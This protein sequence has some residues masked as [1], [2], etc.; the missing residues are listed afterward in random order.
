MIRTNSEYQVTF[1]PF[2]DRHELVGALKEIVNGTEVGQRYKADFY[3]SERE[4]EDLDKLI[5]SAQLLSGETNI[6][7]NDLRK[8]LVLL[9]DSGELQPREF[10]A[11]TKLE[12]PEPDV[13]PRDKNGKLLTQQQIEWAEYRQFAESHSSADCR[14]RARTDSGFAN[15]MRKNLEREMSQPVGDAVVP[16]GQANSQRTS[17]QTSGDLVSFVHAFRAEPSENLRPKGGFVLLSG[18]KIPH[19]Q[20]IEQIEAA[21]NAGLL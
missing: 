20:L 4:D 2:E 10:V 17:R 1:D 3:S 15:F 19:S 21:T 5:R 18:R 8:A 6:S 9:L 14:K 11:V 16:E 7:A 13:R 12:E